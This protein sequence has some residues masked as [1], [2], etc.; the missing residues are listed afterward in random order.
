LAIASSSLRLG[1]RLRVELH[2]PRGLCDHQPTDRFS[3]EEIMTEDMN[4][5]VHLIDSIL[6]PTDFS[7]ASE[8]AFAHALA[9]TLRR[10]ARLTM[11]H[12]SEDRPGR[13]VWDRFPA[14]RETLE[15][16]GQL[17][18]GSPR[19]AV[20]EELGIVVSKVSLKGRKPMSTIVE[21]LDKEPTD[22][23][24]LATQ[25][26]DG[27]ARWIQTS[28]SESLARQ[29]ATSTLFVPAGARGF[30]SLGDGSVHVRKILIPVD[31]NPDPRAAIEFATRAALTLGE[32]KVEATAVHVGDGHDAPPMKLT[33]TEILSW[34]VKHRNGSAVDGILDAADEIAPD[35]I[36]MVTEGNNGILDALRGTTT[37]QVLRRSP[38]PVLAIPTAWIRKEAPWL[39]DKK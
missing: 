19:S 9:L 27:L 8:A 37:E 13:D 28:T 33:D 25:G 24:V 16:W 22:M 36:I 10:K 6:H 35:L 31:H 3:A 30:V 23:I 32:G 21:Y 2:I 7:E 5:N 11:L 14:V 18:P 12:T 26:L 34:K 1:D 4:L 29:S 15:R 38:C 39:A 17:E 20:Y